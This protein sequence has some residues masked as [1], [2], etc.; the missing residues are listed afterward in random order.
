MRSYALPL[1]VI[2]LILKW[3]FQYRKTRD[4]TP[5]DLKDEGYWIKR[6]KNNEAAKRSREKRKTNDAA[7]EARVAILEQMNEKLGEENEEL[8]KC[9]AAANQKIKMLRTERDRQKYSNSPLESVNDMQTDGTT[10][11][12]DRPL[13]RNNAS[14]NPPLFYIQNPQRAKYPSAVEQLD[15]SEP[16]ATNHGVNRLK[17][18]PRTTQYSEQISRSFAIEQSPSAGIIPSANPTI[19]KQSVNRA[20]QASNQ[21]SAATRAPRNSIIVPIHQLSSLGGSQVTAANQLN[22][23]SLVQQTQ[24]RNP[25]VYLNTGCGVM[26]F[27]TFLQTQPAVNQDVNSSANLKH[28]E[29]MFHPEDQAGLVNS[30][31]ELSDAALEEACK[32]MIIQQQ[33]PDGSVV[34]TGTLVSMSTPID[35][36]IP[37]KKR[38]DG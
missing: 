3:L 21:L 16:I 33:D 12:I 5:D 36:I 22:N 11:N 1:S 34:K 6:R 14:Q 25:I 26:P 29:I 15:L 27:N 18:G 20:S 7:L 10:F 4:F 38:K 2:Y 17:S 32:T 28:H 31:G 23:G 9:L 13:K 37:L 30:S 35:H 8:K 19:I 24:N